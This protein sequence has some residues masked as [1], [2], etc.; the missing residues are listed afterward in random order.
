MKTVIDF[1]T[2]TGK[3]VFIE[4][5][6]DRYLNYSI[7]WIKINGKR[8]S[9]KSIRTVNRETILLD[10]ANQFVDIDY[11]FRELYLQSRLSF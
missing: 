7:T 10:Y 4:V 2:P 3:P 11:I 9:G 1:I 6:K 5:H 8:Y